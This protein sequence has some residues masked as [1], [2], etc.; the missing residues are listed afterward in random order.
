MISNTIMEERRRER[1]GQGG[2][3]VLR[4]GDDQAHPLSHSMG[5][6]A[7]AVRR[8]HSDSVSCGRSQHF[9]GAEPCEAVHFEHD[10]LLAALDAF[11]D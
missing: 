3:L 4:M 6:K 10:I 11:R 8:E 2:W 9:E 1:R 7:P 5:T